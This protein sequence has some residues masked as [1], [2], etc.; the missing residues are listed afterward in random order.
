V[1]ALRVVSWNVRDLLGDPLAVHR[2]LRELA[3]DVACLQE[4]PRRLGSGL[5]LAALARGASLV[6]VAGGRS[7][8]GTAVLI[9]PSLDVRAVRALRLP[10]A[11]WH[12]RRRGAV[13]VAV[14]RSG[15]AGVLT[16]ASVHLP[17]I[18]ADRVDHAQR[19]VA[20]L[21]GF[22]P[23]PYA[24]AA[25]FNEPPGGPA[26]EAFAALVLDVDAQAPAT[27]PA[28]APRTR[29]DAVLVSPGLAVT[30]Y[31][32]VVVDA[33]LAARASDHLPV[34]ADVDLGGSGGSV[35]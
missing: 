32:H 35:S 1:T 22:G 15:T 16:V 25:D 34:V 11:R 24:V 31:P 29:L 18:A 5:R 7:T 30:G 27:F 33:V 13:V 12:T 4:V 10:V 26:W 23:G 17:L 14:R 28:R 3:P 20:A 6:A 19:V 21:R 2:V 8:G 9:S